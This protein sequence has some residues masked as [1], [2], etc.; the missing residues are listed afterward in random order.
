VPGLSGQSSAQRKE[1]AEVKGKV[2][3]VEVYSTPSDKQTGIEIAIPFNMISLVSRCHDSVSREFRDS[4]KM[5]LKL[6][7]EAVA[8]AKR[9]GLVDVTYCG[10]QP[11][12]VWEFGKHP[13]WLDSYIGDRDDADWVALIPEHM[14]DAWIG[15]LESGSSFGCCSVREYKLP[16]GELIRVGHHA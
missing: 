11:I 7:T 9:Q 1:V 2:R 4:V 8:A 12:K 10:N 5:P 14:A 13:E 15:W 6:F 16:T 3:V